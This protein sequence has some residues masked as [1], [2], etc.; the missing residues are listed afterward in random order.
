MI[1][2]YNYK[3]GSD[4]GVNEHED[5]T[6]ESLHG[7]GAL[8]EHT[9]FVTLPDEMG[10][11]QVDGVHYM[12]QDCPMEDWGENHSMVLLAPFRKDATEQ[13]A[14]VECPKH[15]FLWCTL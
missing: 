2:K 1:E 15:G 8:G 6:I 13:V 14:V 4:T 10:G 3:A 9:K 11:G 7:F 12:R 5:G